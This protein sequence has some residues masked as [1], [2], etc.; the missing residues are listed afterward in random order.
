RRAEAQEVR[1]RERREGRARERRQRAEELLENEPE[2]EEGSTKTLATLKLRLPDGSVAQ[3]RF[4][5]DAALEQVLAWAEMRGGG[6]EHGCALAC[7]FPRRVFGREDLVKN[8]AELGLAPQA[9]LL[10]QPLL[11]DE[12]EDL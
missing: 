11:E 4:R 2:P 7:T 1:R 8:L 10:V 6:G 5:A 9:A 3:R 12:D